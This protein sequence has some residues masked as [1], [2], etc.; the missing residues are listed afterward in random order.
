MFFPCLEVRETYC[1]FQKQFFFVR[2]KRVT[3]NISSVFYSKIEIFGSVLDILLFF[4]ILCNFQ[5]IKAT[6]YLSGFPE[7]LQILAKPENITVLNAKNK[8]FFSF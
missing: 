7:I 3:D 5:N 8:F 4:F 2:K 1:F 6:C